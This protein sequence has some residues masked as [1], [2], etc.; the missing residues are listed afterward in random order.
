M[1]NSQYWFSA[2]HHFWHKNIIKYCNRPFSSVEEMNEELILRHN[3]VVKKE[4]TT[5]IAGDFC[6]TSDIQEVYK[7]VQ[8][9]NGKII[10]L[11]GSHDRWMKK[12]HFRRHYHEIWEKTIEGIKIVVC[13]YAMRTWAASHYN[14]YHLY[15]HSHGN[16]P[17]QGKS[18]DIGVDTNNFYPYSFNE[19]IEIMKNKPDNFNLI[20]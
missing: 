3:K 18:M 6:M 4:D 9:L 12:K 16:L 2:D 7:I 15:G 10:I 20:K 17:S 1:K 11:K 19:I 8:K 5:I 13:H 14:S